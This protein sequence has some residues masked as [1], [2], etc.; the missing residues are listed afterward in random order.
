MKIHAFY[1]FL[2]SIS[3]E[4]E[5]EYIILKSSDCSTVKFTLESRLAGR[6]MAVG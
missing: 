5:R 2:L 6:E 1:S 3:P 4:L